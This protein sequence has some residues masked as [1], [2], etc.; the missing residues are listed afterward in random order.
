MTKFLRITIAAL[1][2]MAGHAYAQDGNALVA[3]HGCLNCHAVD[4]QKMGPAFT[5]IAAQYQGNAAA[6]GQLVAKLRD[7]AGH[8]KVAASEAEIKAMVDYVLAVK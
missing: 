4:E 5:D 1:G 3:S 8:M 6:E 7:G 2:L